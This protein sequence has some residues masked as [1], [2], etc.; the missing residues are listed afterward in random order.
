[1]PSLIIKCRVSTSRRSRDGR[2]S[3]ILS[4]RRRV[5]SSRV[6]P[7]Q[8]LMPGEPLFPD[9][10]VADDDQTEVFF[11]VVVCSPVDSCRGF[12]LDAPPHFSESPV[13][14]I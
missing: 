6:V 13:V 12:P 11:V 7:S 2:K 8:S 3:N 10:Y 9:T 1:M 5:I 14:G 4:I